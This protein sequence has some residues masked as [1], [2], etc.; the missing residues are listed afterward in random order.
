MKINNADYLTSVVSA[1]K[2]IRDNVPEYAFV[3][4]S[5]VGKSSLI[6]NLCNQK[7]LAKT[8]SSPGRTRMINYFSL[9]GGSARFV[10]LPGYGFSS[11][12]KSFEL[13]W[14]TLMADYFSFSQSLKRVFLLLDVRHKPS[15]DDLLMQ[16]YL[17]IHQIPTTV[18]VTKCDKLSGNQ[19]NKAIQIIANEMC[20]GKANIIAHS[21]ESGIGKEKILEK[22]C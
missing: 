20:L 11:A 1:D 14:Q 21:C 16:K 4:K 13:L 10:D 8:S 18:V 6:N 22:M 2:V 5:N 12:G 17:Y 3:G 7:K 9:N 15:P 19:L